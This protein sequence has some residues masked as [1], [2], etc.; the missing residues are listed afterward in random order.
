MALVAVALLGAEGSRG[1]PLAALVLPAVEAAVHGDHVGVAELGEGVS[2]E[3]GTYATG[4][5]DH[6]GLAAVGE[7]ALDAALE[8]AAWNVHG[9]RD[10]ALFVLVGLTH[11]EQQVTLGQEGLG[12]GRIGLFDTALGRREEFSEGWH[13][14][15]PT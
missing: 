12:P 8:G 6:D 7:A 9:A 5:H 11:V 14:R 10:G 13:D 2:G 1:R 3:R 4:A 15:K